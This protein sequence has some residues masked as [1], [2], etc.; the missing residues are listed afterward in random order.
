M[1]GAISPN[2]AKGDWLARQSKKR[3]EYVG[4]LRW[5]ELPEGELLPVAWELYRSRYGLEA[6]ALVALVM[7]PQRLQGTRGSFD[8]RQLLTPPFAGLAVTL[9]APGT[10]PSVRENEPRPLAL[11]IQCR[12]QDSN[13]HGLAPSGF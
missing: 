12:E 1:R 6:L 10:P 11:D 3:L 7:A 13:L 2:S 8:P 4:E 5:A 9:L